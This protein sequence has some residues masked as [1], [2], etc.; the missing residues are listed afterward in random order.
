MLPNGDV[1]SWSFDNNGGWYLSARTTTG[2]RTDFA[3][4]CAQEYREY[5]GLVNRMLK[6][7]EGKS[8]WPFCRSS[9]CWSSSARSFW[10]D[11]WKGW[12][13]NTNGILSVPLL[14]TLMSWMASRLLTCGTRCRSSSR[15]VREHL[16]KSKKVY[17]SCGFWWK[18]SSTSHRRLIR[19]SWL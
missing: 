11:C 12:Y 18:S 10:R 6:R 16:H 15:G 14:T 4:K 19:R 7:S 9:E 8:P 17:I 2:T 1:V 5:S 3:S 13:F